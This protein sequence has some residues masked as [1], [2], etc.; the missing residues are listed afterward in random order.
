MGFA[1]LL[2]ALIGAGGQIGSALL[3]RGR[4]DSGG[5]QQNLLDFIT[6]L[7]QQEIQRRQQPQP[8]IALPTPPFNPNA[9]VGGGVPPSAFGGINLF[10]LLNRGRGRLPNRRS[11]FGGF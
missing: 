10:D 9:P 3:N 2:P 6:Q 7:S 11:A 1:A 4:R 5:G 8:P